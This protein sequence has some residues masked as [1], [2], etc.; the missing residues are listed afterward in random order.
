MPFLLA[1][2]T[3]VLLLLS[4]TVSASNQNITLPFLPAVDEHLIKRWYGVN[5]LH[6]PMIL[7]GW[8]PWPLMC[9]GPDQKQPIRYCFKDERSRGNLQSTVDQAVARWA[10]ALSP[11]SNLEIGFDHDDTPLCTDPRIRPDA[12]VIS[13]EST[14][15]NANWFDCDTKSTTG[16]L[17]GSSD[18]RGRHTL[19]FCHLKPGDED[20]TGAVAV[21]AMM[22]E[23]GHVM[24]LAHEHQRKDRGNVLRFVCSNIEGYDE[25]VTK[26]LADEEVLFDDDLDDKDR[27]SL[28]CG[29]ATFAQHYFPAALSFIRGDFMQTPTDDNRWQYYGASPTLDTESIMIYN[30]DLGA[31]KPGTDNYKDW[32]MYQKGSRKPVWTGGDRDPTKCAPSAGDI[33]R[34]KQLYPLPPGQ[35]VQARSEEGS[36]RMAV[37]VRIRNEFEMV[38]DPPKVVDRE[39]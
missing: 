4:H 26:A 22:H 12:L 6:P 7:G 9:P 39:L 36:G 28:I 24:G 25:A 33:E 14:D 23:L 27:T 38:V 29:D 18:T 5:A 17:Y 21:Q 35:G 30:S 8:G 20:A 2:T 15:D 13:D 16:Y 37:R 1:I 31:K 34:V 10:H 3:I 19:E 32:V 11:A